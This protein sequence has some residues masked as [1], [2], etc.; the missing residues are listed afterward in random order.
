M[1]SSRIL[2]N[3]DFENEAGGSASTLTTGSLTN[4]INLGRGGRGQGWGK[5]NLKSG[6]ILTLLSNTTTT[7]TSLNTM[8]VKNANIRTA[9]QAV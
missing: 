5:K 1:A 9:L 7:E 8:Y 6:T 2:A 3:F 4:S